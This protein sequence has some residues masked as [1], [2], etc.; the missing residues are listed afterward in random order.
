MNAMVT[1][2]KR[3]GAGVAALLVAGAVL[4]VGTAGRS[5]AADRIEIRLAHSARPDTA[6]GRRLQ[7]F[8]DRVSELSGGRVVVDNHHSG[9]LVME[10]AAARAAM[11]GNI[12]MGSTGYGNLAP[13][14][15]AYQFLELPFLF[16]RMEDVIEILR[17]PIGQEIAGEVEARL[18]LKVLMYTPAGQFQQIANGKREVR[19]PEDLRGLKIRTRPSPVEIAI[20]R[21]LGGLPTPV[22]WAEI[23]T[24]VRQ[25]TVDGLV[26]QYLWI[27]ST[28]LSEVIRYVTELNVNAPVSIGYINLRFWNRLPPDVQEI[29]SRAALETE[30]LGLKWDR[31]EEATVKDR[32]RKL[33]IAIYVPTPAEKAEWKRK[34]AG[35]WDEMKDRIPGDLIQRV[36][37][38][39]AR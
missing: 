24:A 10:T 35:V 5:Q 11:Q 32:L 21:R 2:R 30:P 13:L 3:C 19:R 14:T 18:N 20:V 31:E 27:D 25:G 12:E 1:A 6:M 17:G 23:Y 7:A 22:D 9:K 26:S 39:V 16:E 29:I 8:A 15:T 36:Q 4:T 34:A 38:A 28:K 33:G 37:S